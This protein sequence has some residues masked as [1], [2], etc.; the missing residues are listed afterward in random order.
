MPVP[1]ALP[2]TR[3][4][5]LAAPRY[6]DLPMP[7]YAFVPGRTPH[8]RRHPDGHLYNRPEPAAAPLDPAAWSRSTEYLYGCDLYNHGYWWE[9][10]EAW[11]AIWK[12][13]PRL[14]P[15]RLLLQGLI[16]TGAAHLK[17]FLGHLD[18]TRRLLA[19]ALNF[20]RVCES[21]RSDIDSLHPSST[22]SASPSPAFRN[23]H[24]AIRNSSDLLMGL[25]IGAF[26]AAVE[27]YYTPRL[28]PTP[29]PRAHDPAAFPFIV[30]QLRSV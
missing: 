7:P 24:P 20:L 26:T 29:A 17:Y 25:P 14:S 28:A 22:P 15:Q 13:A 5:G 4:L 9:A 21:P 11:E 12:L 18:G 6:V 16:Q 10:H 30:L 8:P 23:P 2:D 1:D 27:R 3:S 19:R